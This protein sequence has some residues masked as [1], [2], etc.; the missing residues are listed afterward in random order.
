MSTN[1]STT[2]SADPQSTSTST[3]LQCILKSKETEKD[4]KACD[5]NVADDIKKDDGSTG[6]AEKAKDGEEVVKESTTDTAVETLFLPEGWRSCICRYFSVSEI[7]YNF[8]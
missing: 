5:S 4:G 3:Q 6:N 8:L 2:T 1:P 7:L